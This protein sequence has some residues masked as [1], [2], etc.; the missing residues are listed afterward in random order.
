[1]IAPYRSSGDVT[2]PPSRSD[3]RQ[4]RTSIAGLAR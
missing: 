3:C 1:M 4:I 2:P